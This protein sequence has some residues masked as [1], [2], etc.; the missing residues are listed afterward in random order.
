M[1]KTRAGAQTT[2]E[3]I[4]VVRSRR[5]TLALEVKAPARVIVRAPMRTSQK[6]ICEFVESHRAWIAAALARVQARQEAR[7]QAVQQE[8]LLTEEDLAALAREARLIIPARVEHF[9]ARIGVTYGRITLRCQKTRWG[10]C[11]AA[12]NLNFNVLLMLAPPEVLDYVV[13]HELCH[14]LEMNHSAR[15]WDLVSRYDP[16]QRLHRAWLKEHGSTLLAR[17]GK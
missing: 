8:G 4:E 12:G 6:V 16:D 3:G 2:L 7:A 10:S 11:S 17:A 14:R 1:H 13:I 15:F 9:A 5:K